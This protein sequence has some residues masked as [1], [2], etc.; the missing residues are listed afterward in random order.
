MSAEPAIRC[1]GTER[2]Y[3]EIH[4]RAARITAGLGTL[5]LRPGD[6]AALVLRNSVEF[7]ELTLGIGRAGISPVPVNWH[8]RGDELS[9]LL[10]DSGSKVV[11]AHSSFAPLV[12]A[13]APDGVR[14]IE[15]LEPGRSSAGAGLPEAGLVGAGLSGAGLVE[16]E[17]WLAG[18]KAAEQPGGLPKFGVI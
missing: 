18:Q 2:S 15:V 7:L 16:F 13:A 12:T 11:F 1:D 9:Y 6:S 5:G 4:E 17:A 3:L 8:W 14:V 10:R